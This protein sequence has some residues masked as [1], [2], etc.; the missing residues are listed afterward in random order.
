MWLH[1]HDSWLPPGRDGVLSF[2]FLT[3][4]KLSE[5]NVG[6]FRRAGLGGTKTVAVV[7]LSSCGCTAEVV[8]SLPGLLFSVCFE[9]VFLVLLCTPSFCSH[10]TSCDYCG[11]S[12]S[13]YPSLVYVSLFLSDLH[14][15]KKALVSVFPMFPLFPGL[16]FYFSFVFPL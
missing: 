8:F 11:S 12:V 10:P 3:F 4:K 5:R 15:S 7:G 16:F 1:I 13:C 14:V 9:G 2:F 6:H